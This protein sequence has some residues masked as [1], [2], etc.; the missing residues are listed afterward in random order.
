MLTGPLALSMVRESATS[1]QPPATNHQPRIQNCS[2]FSNHPSLSR[3]SPPTASYANTTHTTVFVFL[4][5]SPLSWFPRGETNSNSPRVHKAS[6]IVFPSD[7]LDL[8][9]PASMIPLPIARDDILSAASSMASYGENPVRRMQ[10]PRQS[11]SR[12][13]VC[14]CWPPPA[15]IL[16]PSIH[17]KA[18]TSV[19]LSFFLSFLTSTYHALCCSLFR[20]M[21]V[22]SVEKNQRLQCPRDGSSRT[23]VNALQSIC[24][25]PTV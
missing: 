14:G 8:V 7:V 24:V 13:I 6:A 1:Y 10:H 3:S 25:L 12:Q 19:F 17:K 15:A 16:S 4:L 20:A 21:A 11:N 22:A 9:R 5:G 23:E 2:H 18:P